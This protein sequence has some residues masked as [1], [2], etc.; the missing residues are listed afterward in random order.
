M[1]AYMYANYPYPF[2]LNGV[3]QLAYTAIFGGGFSADVGGGVGRRHL[4][5]ER[6]EPIHL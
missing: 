4:L 1:P 2:Y 6:R 5:P 3:K